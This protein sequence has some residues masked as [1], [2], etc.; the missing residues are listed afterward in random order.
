V[1]SIQ[2]SIW[3]R[4][5]LLRLLEKHRGQNIWDLESG[6]Q[7]SIKQIA[8]IGGFTT[9]KGK[10]RGKLQWDNPM[11]PYIAKALVQGKWNTLDYLHE[12]QAVMRNTNNSFGSRGMNS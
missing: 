10:R 3:N 5:S 4:R 6:A 8:L 1:F 2:P 7:K 12:L 11:Y 9:K